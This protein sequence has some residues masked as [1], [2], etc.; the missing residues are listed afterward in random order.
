MNVT[1]LEY[2]LC[3]TGVVTFALAAWALKDSYRERDCLITANVNGLRWA[4]VNAHVS[5][6]L[7]RVVASFILMGTGVWLVILPNDNS[8]PALLSKHALLLLGICMSVSVFADRVM[9]RRQAIHLD[10]L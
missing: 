4:T 8:V 2:I 5:R 1:M 6:D 7:A 9:R 3:L 10:K